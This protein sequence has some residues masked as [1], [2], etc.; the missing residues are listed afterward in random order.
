M[1]KLS[2]SEALQKMLA[3]GSVYFSQIT[4]STKTLLRWYARDNSLQL[5]DSGIFNT[6]HYY[7]A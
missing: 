3:G 6:R 1:A 2:Y 7:F 5:I 4:E